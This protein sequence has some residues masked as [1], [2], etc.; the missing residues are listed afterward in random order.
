MAADGLLPRSPHE[1]PVLLPDS[2]TDADAHHGS[3]S[4]R[5]DIDGVV[6]VIDISADYLCNQVRFRSFIVKMH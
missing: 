1:P 6:V 2:V 5:R 4:V 3:T